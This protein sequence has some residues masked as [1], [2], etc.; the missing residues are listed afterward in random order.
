MRVCPVE[1]G[2]DAGAMLGS[3]AA[4]LSQSTRLWLRMCIEWKAKQTHAVSPS[5]E[6]LRVPC[7][8]YA[9]FVPLHFTSGLMP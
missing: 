5:Q 6:G 1:T 7:S 2:C 3:K 4:P 9:V 8:Y